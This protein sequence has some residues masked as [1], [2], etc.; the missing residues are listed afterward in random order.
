MRI[1]SEAISQIIK[2]LKQHGEESDEGTNFSF[3]GKDEPYMDFSFEWQQNGG[4]ELLF[5]GYSNEENGDICNDPEFRFHIKDGQIE[6]IIHNHWMYGDRPCDSE[7]DRKYA[8]EF[9]DLLYKRHLR[10]RSGD[11]DRDTQPHLAEAFDILCRLV[12]D[13]EPIPAEI[14]VPL[15][16][17]NQM[18]WKTAGL[19]EAVK[20]QI[21]SSA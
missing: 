17:D 15:E 5:V 19:L 12:Q 20:Q 14:V 3:S 4:G 2:W 8:F 1:E 7:E 6:K 21:A 10:T 11:G 9:A 13:G 16:D 18:T